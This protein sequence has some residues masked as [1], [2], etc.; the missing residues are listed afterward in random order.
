MENVKRK[1]QSGVG[2]YNSIFLNY[3]LKCTEKNMNNGSQ[4]RERLQMIFFSHVLS[5]LSLTP[6]SSL[7]ARGSAGKMPGLE[8][9]LGSTT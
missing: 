6:V 8:G 1:K 7:P 5:A 2:S 4:Q 3:T 9:I